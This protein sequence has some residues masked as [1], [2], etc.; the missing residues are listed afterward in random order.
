MKE[1][2]YRKK[3]VVFREGDSG[4]CMYYIVWGSVGVYI[5]YGTPSEKK[6]A[7]LRQGDYFGEMGLLD[8]EKR[9]ATIVSLD[10]GTVLN[11]ISDAEFKE[12]L[13]TNP[14][15]VMDILRRISHKL[16]DTTK[17]YLEIC[18]AVNTSVG[19]EVDQV[20]ES[21]TYGFDKNEQLKSVYEDVQANAGDNA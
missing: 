19:A 14:A 1:E 15:K 6:L 13:K 12:F 21:R 4:D 10:H 5:G 17:S 18:Q 16:R 9:S 20:V 2:K 8:H 3:Q 7:E 11:R